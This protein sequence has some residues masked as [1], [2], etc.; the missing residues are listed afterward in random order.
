M[1]RTLY[2]VIWT[3]T[4]NLRYKDKFEKR[5][6]ILG[7]EQLRTLSMSTTTTNSNNNDIF[8]FR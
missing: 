7:K 1:V 5:K 2:K 6:Q 3:K 8:I 4:F